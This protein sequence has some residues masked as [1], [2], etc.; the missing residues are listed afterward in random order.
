MF[1][2]TKKLKQ[3][4]DVTLIINA[5]VT[6]AKMIANVTSPAERGLPIKSIIFPIIFPPNKEEDEWEKDC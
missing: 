3:K 6:E 1:I 2:S 5:L 4:I